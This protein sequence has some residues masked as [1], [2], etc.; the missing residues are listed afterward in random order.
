V[1]KKKKL[2][3]DQPSHRSANTLKAY[4]QALANELGWEEAQCELIE[5]AAKLHDIGKLGIPDAILHKAG[6]LDPG[7]LEEMRKHPVI[8][9][10]ML[11]G[12][13]DLI[14]AIPIVLHHHE[15]WDG[16][17][18][19]NGLRGKDI[20]EESRLLA[21]VNAFDVMTSE[22]PYRPSVTPENAFKE[23]VS[24]SGSQFDP[25]MVEDFC[26]CWGRGD[27]HAIL[28]GSQ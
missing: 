22:Q 21:V 3:M 26:R 27:I 10:S 11:E 8:S 12:I 19:P 7:E 13:S 25:N 4:A 18:Y 24:N 23:I 9:A 2:I 14:P 15:N 20:P 28:S 16:S 6:P 17:G 5:L 1:Y